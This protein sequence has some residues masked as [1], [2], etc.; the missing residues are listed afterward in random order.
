MSYTIYRQG[1]S[2]VGPAN[3]YEYAVDKE[4]LFGVNNKSVY[5][6][7][8]LDST[9]VRKGIPLLTSYPHFYYADEFLA[10]RF[11]MSPVTDKYDTKVKNL[12]ATVILVIRRSS[13][14]LSQNLKSETKVAK[15]TLLTSFEIWLYG[16]ITTLK[17]HFFLLLSNKF[18]W[19]AW[20]LLF[21]AS[22]ERMKH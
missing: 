15:K 16:F 22:K 19:F 11:G 2:T 7:G 1:T 9:Q 3:V 12:F 10:R 13:Q 18:L 6:K 5:M 14:F 17:L 8:L 4:T 21:A 20:N